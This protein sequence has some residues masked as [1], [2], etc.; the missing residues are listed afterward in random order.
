MSIQSIWVLNQTLQIC[1]TGC[2]IFDE[3]QV[4]LKLHQNEMK[5]ANVF[6][7]EEIEMLQLPEDFSPLP[8]TSH[9]EI[10]CENRDS[11]S[12][13]RIRDA[14]R[15]SDQ[16]KEVL[17]LNLA[18]PT[19]PGGGVRRGARAQE[20]ELCRASSLLLSLES[21]EASRYYH[22]NRSLHTYMGS[23]AIIITPK[24]ELIR[25]EKGM[26]LPETSVVSV[27][28]CAAPC[29]TIGTMGLKPSGYEEMVYHRIVGMLKVAAACGYQELVLGA[30][31]CGAFGNDA[32]IVSDLFARAIR[33]FS[34][35]GFH[36]DELFR[37]IDFAVLCRNEISYNLREF[38]RN[39][40]HGIE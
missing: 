3:Q 13:A 31:G 39:F 16:T 28:T 1:E 29:L 21:E 14:Q 2:Y 4:H 34:I 12:M 7:P 36:V 22:F 27:M 15:T 8:P 26:L 37:H 35:E 11:F 18:N 30:F 25:D 6:L 20:E 24:V 19:H 5:A 40:A 23:D 33:E 38:Q 32:H 9:C 10:T 17:V